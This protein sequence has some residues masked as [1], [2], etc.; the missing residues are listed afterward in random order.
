MDEIV[1]LEKV[2]NIGIIT[3]NKPEVR[4]A[5]DGSV[6]KA[7]SAQLINFDKD[8]TLKVAVLRGKGGLLLYF[9]IYSHKKRL[10]LCR[11]KFEN[12]RK[13]NNGRKIEYSTCE[14]KPFFRY[15]CIGRYRC[16]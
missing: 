1:S 8:E 7:I 6:A 13:W 15:A 4:N 3:I 2:D 5:F 9:I 11:S 12:C 10:F 16:H 14:C